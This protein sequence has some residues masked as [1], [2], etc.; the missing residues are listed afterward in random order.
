MKLTSLVLIVLALSA[1]CAIPTPSCPVPG[2]S[3]CSG[4]CVA[5]QSDSMNCGSCGTVCSANQACLAGTCGPGSCVQPDVY[6]A[7]WVG[8]GLVGICSDTGVQTSTATIV[9]LGDG[10][11]GSVVVPNLQAGLFTGADTL[12]LLDY[13]NNQLDVV[14]VAKWPPLPVIAIS[15]ASSDAGSDSSFSVNQIVSC[16]GMVLALRTATPLLEGYDLG[17]FTFVNEVSLASDAGYQSPAGVACDGDHTAYVTDSYNNT[18]TAV[19][20]D[21]FTITA[22]TSL[23]AGDQ[24]PPLSD[25]G[26]ISPSLTGVAFAEAANAKVLVSLQNLDP[27]YEPIAAAT[28]FEIDPALTTWSSPI[29]PGAQCLDA[30]QIVISPDQSTGYLA[31]A[32]LFDSSNATTVQP[33]NTAGY[34]GVVS[35]TGATAQAPITTTVSNPSN[36]VVLKNGLLAIGDYS[37]QSEVAFYNP[38]DGGISY[39]AVD[40]PLLPD[41][42]LNPQQGITA[43]IAAP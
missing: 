9:G 40:C 20:L 42:G 41:G 36:L 35:V 8:G 14:D 6:A 17:T 7:C 10:G 3:E 29:D 11:S 22:Q 23:P 25:G 39:V 13:Q 38:A 31:C 30:F 15:A 1:A 5:L 12:W 28:T 16:D 27:S 37:P 34:V 24:L 32:G 19:D 4:T 26:V 18:V 33:Y 2:Q 43:V 21:T